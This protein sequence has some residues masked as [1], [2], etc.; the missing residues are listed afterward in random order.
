MQNKT[1]W[2][3]C[4]SCITLGTILLFTGLF[5]GGST[6]I[7]Y[8]S[9]GFGFQDNFISKDD[10]FIESITTFDEHE[11][12]LIEELINTIIFNGDL[13]NL[14][15]EYGTTLSV[16]SYL[17]KEIEYDFKD[18]I[19]EINI[20]NMD[21]INTFGINF[22]LPNDNKIILTIPE[23]ITTLDIHT[24]GKVEIDQID[25]NHLNIYTDLGNVNIES[26]I[27]KYLDI[28]T[29]VGS[30]EI[31]TSTIS[32]IDADLDL[33]HFAL[34]NSNILKEANIKTDLGKIELNLLGN[35]K[36]YNI[37]SS[38]EFGSIKVNNSPNINNYKDGLID[39]NLNS[40][41][42]TITV[43]TK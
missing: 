23:H 26:S 42:G 43:N 40:S 1:Y 16:T 24:S 25:I 31:N 35:E 36:D 41:M 28:G 15:V 18:N 27:I 32:T 10:S 14:T 22:N 9:N 17:E 6:S 29:D 34:N 38:T 5:L 4:I 20:E 13:C 30:V 12:I 7:Y 33:G 21:K 3:I 8:N 19:L 39:L 11:G 2:T 37:I